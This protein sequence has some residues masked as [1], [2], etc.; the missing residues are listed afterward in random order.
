[1]RIV[2]SSVFEQIV[3]HC[4]LANDDNPRRPTLAVDALL[5]DGDADGPLLV[6]VAD[7]KRM[8]GLDRTLSALPDLRNRGRTELRDGVEYVNFPVW[9]TLE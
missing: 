4:S 3:Y 9:E 1:M 2:A 8:I 6:T 5:R 7:F